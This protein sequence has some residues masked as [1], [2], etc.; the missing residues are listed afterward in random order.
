MAGVLAVGST[1]PASSA[2]S[3]S[4]S[5]SE[6]TSAAQA[7]GSGAEAIRKGMKRLVTDDKYPAAL[8][9][10]VD[11]E[12]RTRNYTAGVADLKTKSKV[13]VDGQVRA[14]SNTKPFTATVVLQLVGEGKI[15]LDSPIETYLPHLVRGEGINGRDITV[16]QLLQHTS[17]LPEYSDSIGDLTG[18]KE[19]HVY[20]QPRTLLDVA[21]THKANFAPGTSWS[22]SN[23]NYVLAGLLIEKVTGRP[24][25]EQITERIINR[26]GLRH[27]YFPEVGDEG[28]REAHPRGYHATKPGAPLDDITE[29]DPSWAWAAGQLIST[30]SDLNRF[31]SA[32]IDGKLLEPAQLTQMRTTV[33]ADLLGSGVRYGLGVTSTPLSCGGL[34]WGH[35]GDIPGYKTRPAVTDDGRAATIAVTANRAPTQQGPADVQALLDTA[36]C[37]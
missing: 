7:H 35:G 10:T 5:A 25:A 1:L 13:P 36:L 2:A 15:D 8:A 27:T 33:P 29:I 4:T 28:I 11:R 37:G 16:R 22:Y 14:G 31:F 23:T 30:P 12:G 6:S 24:L 17:G 9:A 21:L 32:L 3:A 34:M 26:I 18:E 19:R 20:H